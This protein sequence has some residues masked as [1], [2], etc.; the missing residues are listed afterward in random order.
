MKSL[1]FLPVLI[2]VRLFFP[3]IHASEFIDPTGTYIL[4]GEVKN[5]RIISNSGEI[6]ARLL[7]NGKV[8]VCFYINKGYPGYESASFIDT[9]KYTD[10]K[11]RYTPA[12]DA[13]CV[14]VFSFSPV[15][16]EISQIYS[17][18]QGCAFGR[19]ILVSAVFKKTSDDKPVIQ[20]LSAH[21]ISHK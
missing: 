9:L 1:F 15:A 11:T 8:A 5:N 3:A 14:I 21:G 20:D 2:C 4:K 19:G 13:E 7:D 18:P 6:R 10:N 16:A 12:S 17:D